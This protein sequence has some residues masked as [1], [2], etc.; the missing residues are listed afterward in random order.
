VQAIT[1]CVVYKN[2]VDLDTAKGKT[3][4]SFVKTV[5]AYIGYKGGRGRLCSS[6]EKL[7]ERG[8]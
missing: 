8:T 1:G 4:G 2:D 6:G 5:F 3:N 7:I